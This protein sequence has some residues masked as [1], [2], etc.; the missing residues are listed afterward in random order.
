M[1]NVRGIRY[2]LILILSAVMMT[3]CEEPE[4]SM[5][6]LGKKFQAPSL[7][8]TS[9]F[10]Q[11][12]NINGYVR[13]QGSCKP[14]V[15]DLYLSLDETTWF[16]VPAV[17]NTAN[18]NLTGSEV[19]DY[20]CESDGLF[21]FYL[22]K[23]D[24]TSWGYAA[25][26]DVDALYLRGMT[27]IGET[28][29]LKILDDKAPG[30]GN[31]GV[32]GVATQVV[33][34]KTWPTGFAGSSKCE[35]FMAS[36]RDANNH[37]VSAAADVTFTLDK[38]IDATITRN[39]EGFSTF[40]DCNSSTNGKTVFTILA[41]KNSQYIYYRFPNAPLDGAISFRAND[42]NLTRTTS[43]YTVVTLRDSAGDA[44]WM[45]SYAPH[46]VGKGMCTK[47][48][49]EARFYN[50]TPKS[51]SSTN[52]WIPAVTGTNAGKLFFYSDADCLNKVPSINGN[53][54]NTTFYFKYTGTETSNTPLSLTIN[55]TIDTATF[56]DYDDIP[57]KLEID[58]SGN[59][60][61][62][63]IDFYVQDIQTRGVCNQTQVSTHNSQGTLVT[64]NINVTF[65]S[66]AAATFFTSL[67]DCT[68]NVNSVNGMPLTNPQTPLYFK[69]FGAP[70]SAQSISMTSTGLTAVTRS[71]TI[72]DKATTVAALI[73]GQ[74]QFSFPAA[75]ACTPMTIEPILSDL[76]NDGTRYVNT[77]GE[78]KLVTMQMPPEYTHYSDINCNTPLGGTT[79][80][81]N[82]G[83]GATNGGVFTFYI[84]ANATPVVSQ[85]HIYQ[86]T[87]GTTG[88][89]GSSM[90]YLTVGP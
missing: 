6:S 58:L 11:D 56:G 35:Y 27:I 62:A 87:S 19:N 55:H 7:T 45:S 85:F 61:L 54:G 77:F 21:D 36:A 83:A 59:N 65:G 17:P 26:V 3:G 76:A 49:F 86:T 37:F 15:A 41:G 64:P 48:N 51:L 40:A 84:K 31:G 44:Y 43:D 90:I 60:T 23:N 4:V 78:S 22:T 12:M 32:N 89:L 66:T 67:D 14:Q 63:H 9:P 25:N 75:N 81:F 52:A 82:I 53:S 70:G 72:S 13:F 80:G 24:L 74:T 10:D 34:E 28:H 5:A 8:G 42:V 16:L 33:L 73:N 79:L 20:S 57:Q 38:K 50:G 69:V 1:M 30:T 47:G 2:L 29:V 88:Y 71:F 46:K 68:N 18:T 39:I